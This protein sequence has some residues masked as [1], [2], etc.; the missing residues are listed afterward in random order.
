MR[1]L[2]PVPATFSVHAARPPAASTPTASR[3]RIPLRIARVLS[4]SIRGSTAIVVSGNVL[5]AA[6]AHKGAADGGR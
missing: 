4:V 6:R 1:G 2:P 3:D 5:R